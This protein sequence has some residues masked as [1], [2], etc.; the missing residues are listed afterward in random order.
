MT[1]LRRGLSR[2]VIELLPLKRWYKAPGPIVMEGRNVVEYVSSGR[3]SDDAAA[4][5][6][7]DAECCPICLVNFTDGAKIRTLPCGHNF[8]RERID[9]WLSD[10]T[11]CPTCRENISN[12]PLLR[13][14]GTMTTIAA[15][16]NV[17]LTTQPEFFPPWP[18]V[19][20]FDD[21]GRWR[22]RWSGFPPADAG[23]CSDD[24]KRRMTTRARDQQGRGFKAFEGFLG[25][26]VASARQYRPRTAKK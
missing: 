17:F 3:E 14:E 16:S 21:A 5:L 6:E 23:L 4:R 20:G 26:V 1:S 25:G 18:F 13:E 15:A 7:D 2:E 24:D 19:G 8:D 12:T 9:L 10:R 11:T 22:G